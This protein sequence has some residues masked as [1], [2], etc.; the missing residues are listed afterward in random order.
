ML[1][2]KLRSD[3]SSWPDALKMQATV[4]HDADPVS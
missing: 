4:Q 3:N 1:T 2:V